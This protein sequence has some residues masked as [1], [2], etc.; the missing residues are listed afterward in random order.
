MPQRPSK[1]TPLGRLVEQ[2]GFAISHVINKSGIDRK[3]LAYLRTNDKATITLP[4]A[5]A[6]AP[7]FE[8]RLD[9]FAE[10]LASIEKERKE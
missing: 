1:L 8:L 9:Q 10:A 2:K 6:L 3:R 7:V 5:V 4:E